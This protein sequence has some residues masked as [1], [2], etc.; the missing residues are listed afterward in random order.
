MS[1]ARSSGSAGISH[2]LQVLHWMECISAFKTCAHVV[3]AESVTMALS[4]FATPDD[5]APAGASSADAADAVTTAA[6][7]A[8]ADAVGS[9]FAAQAHAASVALCHAATAGTAGIP[10]LEDSATAGAAASG[11]CHGDGVPAA[12]GTVQLPHA[13]EGALPN[14]VPPALP[15]HAAAPVDTGGVAIGADVLAAADSAAV[16]AV[17]L[18]AGT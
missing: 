17:M 10:A 2:C 12:A 1:A 8:P 9:F 3:S 15:M 14:K 6:L 13:S 7:D 5:V 11:P 4:L 16:D 18:Q